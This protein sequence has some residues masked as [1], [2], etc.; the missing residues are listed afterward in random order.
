ML[1]DTGKLTN[2]ISQRFPPIRFEREI[3][4]IQKKTHD[5]SRKPLFKR[6]FVPLCMKKSRNASAI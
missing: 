5:G 1:R 4:I 2:G 3:S 6:V